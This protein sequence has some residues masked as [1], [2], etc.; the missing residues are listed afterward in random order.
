MRVCRQSLTSP[1]VRHQSFHSSFFLL[2]VRTYV[3]T[4]ARTP[5]HPCGTSYSATKSYAFGVILW[6]LFVDENSHASESLMGLHQYQ[7]AVK[8]HLIALGRSDV[9]ANDSASNSWNSSSSNNNNANT[10]TTTTTTS[11]GVLREV[12]ELWVPPPAQALVP[13]C[14]DYVRALF[15]DCVD[16]R[17]SHRPEFEVVEQRCLLGAAGAAFA[18]QHLSAR[19]LRTHHHLMQQQQQQQQQQRRAGT[20]SNCGVLVVPATAPAAAAAAAADTVTVGSHDEALGAFLLGD[21]QQHCA[22]TVVIAGSRSGDGEVVADVEDEDSS[23]ELASTGATFC[24]ASLK[25][26]PEDDLQQQQ[27]RRFVRVVDESAALLASEGCSNYKYHRGDD[28]DGHNNESSFFGSSSEQ[29]QQQTP[30]TEVQ[31]HCLS[32][33]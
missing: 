25:T 7:R 8:D 19:D 24:S 3:R 14:P 6:E 22:P 10:T 11:V 20:A 21:R 23:V 18:N 29:Q 1:S 4:H 26:M 5:A 31:R 17:G 9:I 32:A 12:Q 27:P 2:H 15:G 33:W 16:A 30:I 13:R 28:D